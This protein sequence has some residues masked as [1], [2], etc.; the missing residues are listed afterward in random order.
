M[1]KSTSSDVS[2][3][4]SPAQSAPTR[5][6]VH[7]PNRGLVAG[8]TTVLGGVGKISSFLYLSVNIWKR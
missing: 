4:N 1:L 6:L 3:P 7:S 5:P 2:M 8:I